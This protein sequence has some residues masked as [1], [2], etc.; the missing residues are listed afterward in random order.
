MNV[1]DRKAQITQEAKKIMDS[2]YGAIS[3]VKII[4]D[5]I[6]VNREVQVREPV[7]QKKDSSSFKQKILKN[8]PEHDGDYVVAE[9]KGW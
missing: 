8:A 6:G 4:D 7:V 5:V 2:F 3:S 9:K 1:Q